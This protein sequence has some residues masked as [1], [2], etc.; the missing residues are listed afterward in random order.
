MDCV[1]LSVITCFINEV[2]VEHRTNARPAEGSYTVLKT[3]K[4][5]NLIIQLETL[6]LLDETL[7]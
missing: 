4:L 6:S 3:P 2:G 5:C 1:N 7:S